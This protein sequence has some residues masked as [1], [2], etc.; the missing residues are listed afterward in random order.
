MNYLFETSFAFLSL[1]FLFSAIEERNN[2]KKLFSKNG[3]IDLDIE[4]Y[5]ANSSSNVDKLLKHFLRVIF[6]RVRFDILLYSRVVFML[7]SFLAFT[8]S[9]PI[10]AGFI[11]FF[12]FLINIVIS[13]RSRYG[14]DGTFHMSTQVLATLFIFLVLGGTEFAILM[15]FYFNV[16]MMLCYFF[17][18]FIK[19]FG[20][21]W[22]NGTCLVGIF[23]TLP[24]GH[25]YAAKIF[26]NRFFSFFVCWVVILI[27]VAISFSPLMD[28]AF[29]YLL[30]LSGVL[31]HLSFAIFM[32][33]NKFFYTWMSA[34]PLWIYSIGTLKLAVT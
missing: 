19:I 1:A 16:Q 21:S 7:T 18:G 23:S 20:P 6:T 25:P 15:A 11:I 30:L 34:Y 5:Y 14:V 31:L 29:F 4:L 3:L 17:S 26:E 10:Y 13:L 33:L 24:Y 32:G 9:S 8:H 22:R 12:V 28:D 27:E 2:Y